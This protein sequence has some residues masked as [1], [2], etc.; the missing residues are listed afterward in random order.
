MRVS[1]EVTIAY[2]SSNADTYSELQSL[3]LSAVKLCLD[4]DNRADL[5][6]A[7]FTTSTGHGKT[8]AGSSCGTSFAGHGSFLT[9]HGKSLAGGRGIRT[10]VTIRLNVA[11]V[12]GFEI[13]FFA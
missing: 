5:L 2:M 11:R 6:G 9:G 10:P 8:T 13:S 4:A 7:A 3:D 1:F 12:T